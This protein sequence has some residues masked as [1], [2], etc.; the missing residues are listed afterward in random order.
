MATQRFAYIWRYSI[1]PA[2]RS[3]FLAAY[4]PTGEWARLFAR[5]PSYI[6]TL[7]L[8]DAEDDNRYVT[9]DFWKSRA[10]R[11]AFRKRYSV[12]YVELDAKCDAFTREERFLG[13]YIETVDTSPGTEQ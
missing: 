1:E 8:L 12:E 11:D 10:D 9:I 5:D 2:R 13:D 7:L 3:E 6:E 4:D